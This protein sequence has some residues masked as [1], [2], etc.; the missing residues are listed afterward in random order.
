MFRKVAANL[1]ASIYLHAM[2]ARYEPWQQ[3]VDQCHALEIKHILCLTSLSEINAKSESYANAINTKQLPARLHG[4]AVADFSVPEQ[5]QVYKQH[6]ANIAERV[7]RGENVIIHCAAGIGR[8]G[9]AA[10]CLLKALGLNTDQ[11]IQIVKNAGS[12]PETNQQLRFIN[13]YQIKGV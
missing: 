1:G 12:G 7:K 4:C 10:V 9:C 13:S 5:I 11:A 2:P 3:F 6:I 8:T